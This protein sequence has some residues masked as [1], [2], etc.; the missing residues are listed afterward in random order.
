MRGGRARPPQLVQQLVPRARG[1][2]VLA[3]AVRLAGVVALVV[4]PRSLPLLLASA[5]PFEWP[6][7][8]QP[9]TPLIDG[10]SMGFRRFVGKKGKVMLKAMLVKPLM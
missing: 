1:T 5:V 9:V 3:R 7:V 10:A 4:F 2:A 6:G 8:K